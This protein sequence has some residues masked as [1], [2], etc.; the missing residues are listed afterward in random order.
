MRTSVAIVFVISILVGA[1]VFAVTVVAYEPS[2]EELARSRERRPQ[3][4]FAASRRDFQRRIRHNWAEGRLHQALLDAQRE[5]ERDPEF[6]LAWFYRA[7]LAQ[8]V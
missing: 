4:S 3:G 7:L 1:V 2:T 6:P 5:T 8:D